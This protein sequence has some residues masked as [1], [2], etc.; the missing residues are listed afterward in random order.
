MLEPSART[1]VTHQFHNIAVAFV[2]P[3]LEEKRNDALFL[4][5]KDLQ[6]FMPA[7]EQNAGDVQTRIADLSL[8]NQRAQLSGITG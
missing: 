5:F 2:L 1:I 6:N 4:S 7:G 8:L 3:N